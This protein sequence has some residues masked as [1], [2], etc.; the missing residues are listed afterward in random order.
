MGRVSAKKLLRTEMRRILAN[1]D[2]RWVGAASREVCERLGALVDAC[3]ETQVLRD[4]LVWMPHFPGEIDLANFISSQLGHASVYV[5]RTLPDAKMDFLSID[6]G[7]DRQL[8]PGGSGILEPAALSGELYD[9]ARA[10]TTLVV[11]PGLSFDKYG[12]RLGRGRGYY[13]RF[14]GR[15]EM[16]DALKV[17]VCFEL[18]MVDAVPAESFDVPMDWVVTEERSLR[19]GFSTLDDK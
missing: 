12:N 18:Q 10:G 13:D 7:W 1:L 14:L 5:P 3:A 17:G 9:S 8:V 19:T 16:A 2:H 15:P 11:V 6:T 4:V